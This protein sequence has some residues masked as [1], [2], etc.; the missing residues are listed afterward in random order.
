MSETQV[1]HRGEVWK[2]LSTVERA[3]INGRD[4]HVLKRVGDGA[5][6]VACVGKCKT[7]NN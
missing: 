1:I 6:K 5:V 2:V 3:S 7:I 4:Q